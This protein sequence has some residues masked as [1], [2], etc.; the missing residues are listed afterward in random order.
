MFLAYE[1][2]ERSTRTGEGIYEVFEAAV[3]APLLKPRKMF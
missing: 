1:Y 3:S 2:L